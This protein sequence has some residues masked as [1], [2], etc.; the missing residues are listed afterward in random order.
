MTAEKTILAQTDRL[1]LRRFC[2]CDL[3]DLYE[4]LSD[5]QV[6]RYEPYQPMSIDETAEDLRFRMS[7]EE[8]IAVELKSNGKMIG[9]VYWG[10]RGF[11]AI[12]M[13]YVF[14]RQYWGHGYA[15]ESCTA[16]IQKA[17]SEDT[18]RIYAECDPENTA[19]WHLLERLGF[20]RE[21]YHKQNIYFRKDDHG[22]PIWKD[23]YVYAM[24]NEQQ[25]S[26]KAED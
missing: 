10:K 12:E 23:T 13:G 7:S 9:N 3:Q 17:F 15:T 8:M 4:Y 16:L 21:A 26:V 22:N 5:E 25:D 24:L 2:Q 14:N 6:V 1:I 20:A 18:H 11:Q 19:S